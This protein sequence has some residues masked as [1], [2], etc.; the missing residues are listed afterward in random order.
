MSIFRLTVRGNV[1]N[2]SQVRQQEEGSKQDRP[3]A[4]E[5]A[6]DQIGTPDVREE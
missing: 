4:E 5:E 3:C 2:R 6:E 1:Q